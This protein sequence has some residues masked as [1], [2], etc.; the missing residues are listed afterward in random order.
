MYR[1]KCFRCVPVALCYIEMSFYTFY[2]RQLLILDRERKR[3]RRQCTLVVKVSTMDEE[4]TTDHI[5]FAIAAVYIV[6]TVHAVNTEYLDDLLYY[7]IMLSCMP[8]CQ[9]RFPKDHI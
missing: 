6:S 5:T 3:A 8:A 7:A 4:D 1:T 9:Y 2:L